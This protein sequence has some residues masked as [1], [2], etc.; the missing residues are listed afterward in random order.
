MFYCYTCLTKLITNTRVEKSY[1]DK[2]GN[3]HSKESAE[4]TIPEKVLKLPFQ[5]KCGNKHSKS[6]QINSDVSCK[7]L[8][9]VSCIDRDD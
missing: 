3:N 4:V 1:Q 6:F 7:Q 2:C 8:I 5:E 9:F